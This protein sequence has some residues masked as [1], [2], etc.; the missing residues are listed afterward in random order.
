MKGQILDY[1][2]ATRSGLILGEDGSRYTFEV[3]Q[4]NGSALPKAGV[5]V[6]F[7]ASNGSAESIYQVVG[8]SSG[9]SKKLTAALLAFFLGAFGVHKFFL[10]YNKQGVIMLLVFLFGWILLGIP[11]LIIGV[12]A[13]IEFI[14]YLTKSD[15]EFEQI[16]VVSKK[17]WF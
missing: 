17:P 9:N 7:S 16:Y 15:D 3:P 1:N 14:I 11:S 2:Q 10:G 5:Q 4:W 13:F 12:I 8:A 6:D